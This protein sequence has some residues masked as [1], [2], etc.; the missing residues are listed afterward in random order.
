MRFTPHFISIPKH[1]SCANTAMACMIG[2]IGV[3]L[4]LGLGGGNHSASAA[5]IVWDG[6][7]VDDSNWSSPD[8]W[9][10]N[11]A[12]DNPA[13]VPVT[14]A[15][16]HDA[17][18]DIVQLSGSVRT[19]PNVDTPWY[20]E[21]LQF[22]GTSSF[23]LSGSTITIRPATPGATHDSRNFLVNSSGTTQTINNNLVVLPAFTLNSDG[24]GINVG[25]GHTILNGNLTLQGISALR[26]L[27]GS[28]TVT[29]NGNII[30]ASGEGV[31][32]NGGATAVFNGANSHTGTTTVWSGTLKLGTDAPVGGTGVTGSLGN[33]TSAV[34]LGHASSSGARLL[35]TAAVT[36][37][38]DVTFVATS[39]SAPVYTVGGESAHISEYT[40][41]IYTGAASGASDAGILTAASGGRVNINSIT[42]RSNAT[43]D[44]AGD[45]II[46]K[47]GLGIVALTGTSNYSGNTLV[48]AGTLLVNGTLSATSPNATSVG[49]VT[50]FS[51][52]TLGGTGTIQRSVVIQNGGT[53]AAGNVSD[54]GVNLGGKLTLGAGLTL[55]NTSILNFDLATA[56]SL[57]DDEISVIG[58]LVLDGVLNVT[59]IGGF[60]NGVYKLFDY[61]GSLTNNG[62]IINSAPANFVYN[63]DVSTP[64]SIFLVVTPEPG[65]SALLLMGGSLLLFRRRRHS[66]ICQN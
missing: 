61:T 28:G 32:I 37:A 1:P 14:K 9:G 40:G 31:A 50:V 3:G 62:L 64:G 18:L 43:E 29:I 41:T 19:N 6:G 49:N 48:N 13:V 55:D 30:M 36:I 35:T 59:D 33:S 47:N 39:A 63:I 15:V 20:I 11:V 8:N 17:T 24:S 46:N 27:G 16:E 34:T 22:T 4:G 44:S 7:D 45:D 65:L 25:S 54:A 23:T 21:N 5:T 42:R 12:P 58:S 2:L 56:S 66:Q 10:G 26:I 52:A 57:L 53:L 51:T 38:R 60:G